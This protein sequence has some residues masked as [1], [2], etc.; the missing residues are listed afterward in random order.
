MFTT[1]L[2]RD[3][4][5][6]VDMFDQFFFNWP[7]EVKPPL[8]SF[9]IV[10]KE[11]SLDGYEIQMALAGFTENDVKVY[12]EDRVL[13]IEGNNTETKGLSDRFVC[14]FHHKIPCSSKLDLE[15]TKVSLENGVLSI[16]IPRLEKAKD[17]VY[18]FNK[19]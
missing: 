5:S 12:S 6:F 9:P 4:P 10:N 18:L 1:A 3:I 16:R 14:K 11:N 17:R 13:H 8:D 7:T 19:D 15:A 2:S